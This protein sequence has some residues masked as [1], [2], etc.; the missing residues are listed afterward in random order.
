MGLARLD[1]E[2]GIFCDFLYSVLLLNE[3]LGLY[4]LERALSRPQARWR[5]AE[6]G[7]ERVQQSHTSARP[8]AGQVRTTPSWP[9]SWANFSILQLYSYWDA[10]AN[11]H[12]LG[13]LDTIPF[14]LG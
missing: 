6:R 12:R 9:R 11:L 5:G 7:A 10:W 4:F 2:I 3:I 14:S 1:L 13:R 8:P